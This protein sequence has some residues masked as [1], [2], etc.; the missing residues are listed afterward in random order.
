MVCGA[1]GRHYLIPPDHASRLSDRKVVMAA[2]RATGGGEWWVTATGVAA[3]LARRRR[4]LLGMFS[5]TSRAA[6]EVWR[7][8]ILQFHQTY[9]VDHLIDRPALETDEGTPWPE[10]DLFDYGAER[11]LVVDDP[12]LVDLF[13]RNWVH[14][15]SRTVIVSID[16]YP[17][18]ALDLAKQLVADRD[19]LPIC[20]LHHS[21]A[22]PEHMAADTRELLA[23]DQGRPVDD[24]GLAADAPRRVRALHPWRRIGPASVD[25][26]PIGALTVGVSGLL[27]AITVA[28]SM[29]GGGDTSHTSHV[30]DDASDGGDGD[31]G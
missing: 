16:G 7:D 4:P 30:W 14:S 29:D 18:R 20:L 22:A 21:G 13:V 15:D 26:L 8:T 17:R 3:V 1:C 28:G 27:A 25:C 9:P 6:F 23:V 11:V 12:L 19:D 31:F 5:R 24:L 2:A 10:P